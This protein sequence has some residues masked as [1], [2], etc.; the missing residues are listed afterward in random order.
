MSIE[1]T[2]LV[3]GITGSIGSWMARTILERGGHIVAVVRADTDEAA[4]IRAKE[5]FEVVGADRYRGH[6]EVIHGD[7][8][9]SNLATR[10]AANPD[11][12]SLI[13]NCA[14][15]LEFGQEYDELN[16][17][18]NVQGTA[19]L[20]H[21]AK[22][23]S[24][25]FCHFSTAYI[26]GRRQGRVLENEIDIGQEFHN[27][28][29]FS[30]CQA[31]LLIRKWT[32]ETQLDAFVF[33]PSIVVGDSREGRIVHFDG[34]YNFMRVFDS[35]SSA[36][37]TRTFRVVGD[38]RVTK[39]IVPANYVAEAAWHILSA[40]LPGTYHITNPSPTPLATIRDI[41]A[42]LFAIPGVRLADEDEFREKRANKLE[43]LCQKTASVYAP[44]LAAEPFFDRTVADAALLDLDTA[45]PEMDLVFFRKLLVFARRTQW[46]KVAPPVESVD[47]EREKFVDRYFTRF[48]REKMHQQLLPNL[49]NLSATCRIV[50]ED[51]PAQ[52]WS[53]DIDRGRLER[54]ST[55]GIDYQCVFCLH[56]DVFSSIVCGKLTPQRAF[57]ERK[58]DIQGDIETGL[59]LT[60]VL[61][62][63]FKKWP[64][65]SD[66]CH[67][68]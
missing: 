3:T 57:F 8:C 54:I 62:A 21:L 45:I 64:Y 47:R 17:R 49:K 67:V 15:V 68:G 65:G 19:N 31:E 18:V 13:V 46:G 7:I 37:G 50:V 55:N 34:L 16:R 1:G 58:V 29:E 4:W 38:P 9:D 10:L 5:A 23:L 2:V 28:Y 42:E 66:T 56:S 51:L 35:I 6:L 52:S 48:L 11:G 30:K 40:R 26:A 12:L 24:I 43:S 39:N 63:F 32:D 14:G 44:Y 25:P 53:L 27:P 41:F 60:T 61:A 59:K 33:R 36:I 22:T 20:L